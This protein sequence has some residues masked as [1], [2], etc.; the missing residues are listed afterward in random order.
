MRVD[1]HVSTKGRLP[2]KVFE[3]L[4]IGCDLEQ[5][6]GF[7]AG[8]EAG[9]L[10]ERGVEIARVLRDLHPRTGREPRRHD[11]PSCMPSRAGRQPVTL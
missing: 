3:Y 4:L 6:H 10:L 1:S 9:L 8:G 7:E 11:E 2:P 5:A